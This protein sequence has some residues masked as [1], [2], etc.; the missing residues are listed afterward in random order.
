MSGVIIRKRLEIRRRLRTCQNNFFLTITRRR[1]QA[2]N[3][4]IQ[5]KILKISPE[6]NKKHAIVIRK[7]NAKKISIFFQFRN[8]SELYY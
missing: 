5:R 7:R 4:R 6:Q 3:I 2:E 1:R 8:I